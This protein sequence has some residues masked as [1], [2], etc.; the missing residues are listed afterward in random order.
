MAIA[1]TT[2]E[3]I[4]YVPEA[5]R[6]LPPEQQTTFYLAVLPNWMMLAL[7]QMQNEARHDRWILLALTAGLRGWDNF[8]DENGVETPFTRETRRRRNIAGVEVLDPVSEASLNAV[9]ANLLLELAKAIIEANQLT[10][11]E[12]KN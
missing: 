5:E 6:E 1:R 7:L 3:R 11:A 2:R 10:S 12:A 9:P 8:P 4:P